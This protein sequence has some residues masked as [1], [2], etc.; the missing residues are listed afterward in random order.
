MAQIRT[1]TNLGAL[2]GIEIKVN[3]GGLNR[4]VSMFVTNINYEIDSL[5]FKQ[6][7]FVNALR[8]PGFARISRA[9]R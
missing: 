9:D 5:D 6:S 1:I 8:F 2:E 3:G 4:H 7:L